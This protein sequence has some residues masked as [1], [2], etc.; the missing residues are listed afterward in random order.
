MK[1]QIVSDLH[2]EFG[3]DYE[4]YEQMCETEADVLVLA[5]DIA[6]GT[7]ILRTLKEIQNQTGKFI[8]FVPGN[9]EYYGNTRKYLD[10]QL[11]LFNRTAK[12]IYILVEDQ[13]RIDDVVFL[14]STGWW[15]GSGGHIGLTVRNSLND[16]RLI[17]DIMDDGDDGR[18]WGRASK[19]FFET[20]LQRYQNRDVKVV[21]VSHH[22]PHARSIM[23]RYA[24]SPL[25]ACF[26]NRWEELIYDYQPDLWIH[27]HTHGSFKYNVK[28]TIVVCNPQ[29]YPITNYNGEDV[30]VTTMENPD[31]NPSLVVEI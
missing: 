10:S 14:G 28:D 5:G 9:H 26:V 27:G 19:S 22:L 31:Y 1:I 29:G 17:G 20:N 24:S 16:F 15:D 7:S 18:S 8:I 12:N 6:S 3:V 25:N 21:C 23:P 30:E 2:L 11:K 4:L 13:F